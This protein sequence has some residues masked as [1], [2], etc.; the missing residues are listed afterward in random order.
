MLVVRRQECTMTDRTPLA[1]LPRYQRPHESPADPSL[2]AG[3]LVPWERVPEVLA[4][5]SLSPGARALALGLLRVGTSAVFPGGGA[6]IEYG[7]L[8]K[9]AVRPDDVGPHVREAAAHLRERRVDVLLVPGMS[10]Y[11][12]GAMYALAAELPAILLKKTRLTPAEAE[13]FP[14]G[15]FVIPS[16]TGDGD[17]VMSA[18]PAAALDIVDRVCERQLAAQQDAPR[19]RLTLRCAGADDIIDKATMS[20]A[21]GE[22]A[23]VIGNA[24]LADWL[25]RHRAVTGDDRPAD[26]RVE[27]AAWAA[28]LIKSYNRPQEALRRW[29]G[30]EAFAGLTV[31]GLRL[32]PPALGIEGAG[33]LAFRP[34]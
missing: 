28:P 5:S 27:I 4:A 11:P 29:F 7:S 12:I 19:L 10:G 25:E 18:D 30:I 14:P 33:L 3:E 8:L 15:A 31:T 6:G 17:V 34:R 21:V 1:A 22:S 26:L 32:D 16:Y 2:E 13:G 23:M 24:A 20:Q 9:T